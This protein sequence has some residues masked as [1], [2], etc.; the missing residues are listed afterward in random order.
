MTV[1]IHAFFLSLTFFS[2]EYPRAGREQDV[3]ETGG[4]TWK[5]SYRQANF[6]RLN[7]YQCVFAD[8]KV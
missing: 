7:R 1:E 5:K 4:D 2:H 3:S 8:N 6:R